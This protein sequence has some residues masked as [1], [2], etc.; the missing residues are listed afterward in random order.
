MVV[1]EMDRYITAANGV[2]AGEIAS[3]AHSRVYD[4]LNPLIDDQETPPVAK[5]ILKKVRETFG[6]KADKRLGQA[7]GQTPVTQFNRF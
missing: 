6:N 7:Y 3:K 5:P 2:V 1:S 4:F